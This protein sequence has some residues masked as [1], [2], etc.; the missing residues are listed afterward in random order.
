MCDRRL[1]VP[2]QKIHHCRACGEGFCHECSDY[3][4]PV[5]ERGWGPEEHVRVCRDC[6]GPLSTKATKY[7]DSSAQSPVSGSASSHQAALDENVNARK[8]GEKVMGTLN[9]LASVVLDYPLSALKD[10][11][12]PAYWLPDEEC[13]QCCVCQIAFDPLMQQLTPSATG[14][15]SLVSPSSS[16]HSLSS[17]T[18]PKVKLHHCRQCGQ[19][20]CDDCSR[21]RKPVPLRGWDTPVRVCD[22]CINI[23]FTS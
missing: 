10:S 8:Y 19:G 16:T 2:S 17:G 1:D 13:I 18:T 3:K 23:D 15:S 11:A 7:R 12:R 21:G 22:N 9:N 6:Y 20:V 4:R 5:P 14:G